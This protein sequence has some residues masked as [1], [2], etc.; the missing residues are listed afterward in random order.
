MT[1]IADVPFGDYGRIRIETIDLTHASGYREVAARDLTDR[2]HTV[3]DDLAALIKTTCS[4]LVS[5]FRALEPSTAPRKVT[6]EVG[7]QLG[8]EG[9]LFV[10]KTSAQ[11]NFKL[12]LEWE[13]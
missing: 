13:L 5:S 7:I 10:T 8:A 12:V 1:E 9:S 11:A 2:F 4:S 6:A 3:Y